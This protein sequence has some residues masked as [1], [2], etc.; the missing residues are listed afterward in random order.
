MRICLNCN[1]KLVKAG[2]VNKLSGLHQRYRCSNKTCKTNYYN[3]INE[4]VSFHTLDLDPIDDLLNITSKKMY[5]RDD[6]WIQTKLKKKKFVVT[7]AQSNT[8]VNFTFLKALQKYCSHNNA[9]LLIIPIRYR[10]PTSQTETDTVEHIYDANIEEY[11]FENNIKLHDKLKVLGSLKIAATAEYPLTGLAP[12]SKGDS[13][14]IGHNQLQLTTLPVQ[15][16]DYP[17]IMTTTG[18]VSEKNYSVSKQGYKAEFNHS[19][20]A[21]IIELDDDVFHLRHLN[22]DGEGF[23][24]F[25]KYYSASGYRVVKNPVHTIVTGDEHAIWMDENVMKATY[26]ITGIVDTL[27]PK[28]IV[29]HDVLD[30]YSIS[31]HHKNNNL[32][33]FKKFVTGENSIELELSDTVDLICK[34]TPKG[35]TNIIVSSNHNDHLTKW[36][37][38]CDIKNEPWNALTYHELMYKMLSYIGDEEEVPNPFELWSTEKFVDVG[39]IVKF[40]S[41]RDSLKMFDI[42]ISAHGDRGANGSRGSREQFSKLPAKCIIGHSHSPGIVRGCYQTGTSSTLKLEYNEGPS[43]WLASHCLIYQNG[44]RQLINIVNCKWRA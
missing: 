36:L 4:T 13:V 11:L 7:S 27:H 10:N 22:F 23:Y 30:C 35:T 31:H 18:T 28:F 44:K 38:E 41:R 34:T 9:E 6:Q 20:S 8:D 14:I 29:R 39:C 37:N 15:P 12:I 25:N 2:V 16:D 1:H 21:V 24:D 19:F 32:T 17:V 40:A 26:G 43:S 5:V 42:E 3:P 33:K